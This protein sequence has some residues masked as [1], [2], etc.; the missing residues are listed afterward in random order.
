M[1]AII[2]TLLV[3]S[4]IFCSP[5]IANACV[6]YTMR[7]IGKAKTTFSFNNRRR[8]IKV[9]FTLKLKRGAK[10]PKL[11]GYRF[12]KQFSSSSSMSSREITLTKTWDDTKQVMGKVRVFRFVQG[13]KYCTTLKTIGRIPDYKRWTP[14]NKAYLSVYGTYRAYKKSIHADENVRSVHKTI[15]Q[16]IGK[17]GA[18]V[19]SEFFSGTS[20][21]KGGCGTNTVAWGKQKKRPEPPKAQQS[22]F[23]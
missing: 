8:T 20:G 18:T 3:L 6:D 13:R 9:C 4:A 2:T 23:Q 14:K 16:K 21:A 11:I 1:K 7:N 12:P 15:V 5:V 19:G 22:D 17:K 10:A